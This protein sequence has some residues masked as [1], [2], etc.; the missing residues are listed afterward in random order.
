MEKLK[1]NTK[2]QLDTVRGTGVRKTDT[3]ED[4]GPVKILKVNVKNWTQIITIPVALHTVNS[5]SSFAIQDL[6]MEQIYQ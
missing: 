1:I 3:L 4:L 5:N 2:F 6:P